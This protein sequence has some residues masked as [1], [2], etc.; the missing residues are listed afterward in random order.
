[1]IH[2]LFPDYVKIYKNGKTV[3]VEIP[4]L[5]LKEVTFDGVN[6]KVMHWLSRL[7][8]SFCL[9]PCWCDRPTLQHSLQR[10]AILQVTVASWMKGKTC[11]VCGNNDREKENEF[12]M[13]NH[14]L[15]HSCSAFVHSWVLLE[16]TCSGGEWIW[17][18][19]M[20]GLITISL[21]L[22]QQLEFFFFFFNQ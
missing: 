8:L 2:Y 18:S 10:C 16:E 1:M 20:L 5:G 9:V 11:G 13:P 14:R 15:A 19:F 3:T 7:L 22:C 17:K 21:F 4:E 12:L 6:L